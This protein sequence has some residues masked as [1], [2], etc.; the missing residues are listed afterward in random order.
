MEVKAE[1]ESS[2]EEISLLMR[3]EV[4]EDKTPALEPT[5]ATDNEE[6]LEN[7]KEVK[8]DVD[9]DME[10]LSAGDAE[11]GEIPLGEIQIPVHEVLDHKD[12]EV[13]QILAELCNDAELNAALRREAGSMIA[14]SA[15]SAAGAAG[16]SNYKDAAV[17]AV[18]DNK[19][20]AVSGFDYVRSTEDAEYKGST[21]DAAECKERSD[22]DAKYVESIEAIDC[23][24]SA[25]VGDCNE[26]VEA[27]DDTRSGGA[28][29][30]V[31]HDYKKSAAV[32]NYD[33]KKSTAEDVKAEISLAEDKIEEIST[34][35]TVVFEESPEEAEDV[36]TK[37]GCVKLSGANEAEGFV[38]SARKMLQDTHIP[39]KEKYW[40]DWEERNKAYDQGVR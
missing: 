19:N 26:A 36:D 11:I 10:K 40:T 1:R 4:M 25:R 17:R 35:E 28:E 39:T 38:D 6:V 12:K 23:K 5:R 31:S 37:P 33:I 30:A 34:D 9:L 32:M 27:C 29:E 3:D 7:D 2:K 18:D 21:R 13:D 14:K 15:E 20:A 16:E 22:G 8:K 24:E